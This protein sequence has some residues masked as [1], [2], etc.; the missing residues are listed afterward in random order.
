MAESALITIKRSL[1]K[2]GVY[3]DTLYFSLTKSLIISLN[4]RDRYMRISSNPFYGLG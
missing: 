3:A 4:L 2:N 1:L